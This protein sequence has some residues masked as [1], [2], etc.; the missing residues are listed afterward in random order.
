MDKFGDAVV[1]TEK[2][3]KSQT[4]IVSKLLNKQET[5]TNN[6]REKVEEQND[7]LKKQHAI[8]EKTYVFQ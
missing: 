1:N 3:I 7:V 2:E 6:V 4:D 5:A 8:L